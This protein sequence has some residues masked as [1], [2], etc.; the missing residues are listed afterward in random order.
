[1]A[2]PP[3]LP[4]YFENLCARQPNL[5]KKATALAYPPIRTGPG[6]GTQRTFS[7]RP[8]RQSI[9]RKQAFAD[10]SPFRQ[11]RDNMADL[12]WQLFMQL[13]AFQV[14]PLQLLLREEL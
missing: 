14:V 3:P 5:Q 9:A 6:T 1:M 7:D 2:A 13:L 10:R 8:T 4:M 11:H 12:A